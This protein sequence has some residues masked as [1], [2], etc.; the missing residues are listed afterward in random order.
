MSFREF[1][2]FSVGFKCVTV[3]FE[4]V[5]GGFRDVSRGCMVL[6]GELNVPETP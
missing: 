6:H 3:I 5:E 2:I 1:R 4:S